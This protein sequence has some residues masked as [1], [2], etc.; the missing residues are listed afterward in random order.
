MNANAQEGTPAEEHL[1]TL[2][3]TSPIEEG[4]PGTGK[5]RADSV[6]LRDSHSENHN[7]HRSEGGIIVTSSHFAI[8]DRFR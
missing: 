5:L 7:G 8:T 4:K 1:V 3:P 6:W 2:V